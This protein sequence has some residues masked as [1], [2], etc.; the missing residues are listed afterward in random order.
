MN[1]SF[2]KVIMVPGQQV[3]AQVDRKSGILYLSPG[4][5]NGLPRDQKDFV[6]FHEAGHLKLNTADEFR[7]NTYA[8]NKFLNA[9]SFNNR[10]FGQRIMVMRDVLDKA[11]G[12]IS[13][14]TGIAEGVAG[15]VSGIAQ[16]LP[17]LGVGSKARQKEAEA[18]A[19]AASQVLD[20]QAKAT[21]A[22]TKSTLTII[23]VAGVVV[24]LGII[25]FLTLRKK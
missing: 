5:W 2:K 6:L 15:A 14:L 10:E 22:K 18:N 23:L 24:I 17:V 8:V 16:I 25:I 3:I 20:S 12:Q 13:P 21:N 7:A 11:D 4:I 9:G 19:K 1:T